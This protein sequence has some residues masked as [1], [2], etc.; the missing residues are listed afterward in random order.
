MAEVQA[1]RQ[2]DRAGKEGHLTEIPPTLRSVEGEK[3]SAK[4]GSIFQSD[5]SLVFAFYDQC[6]GLHCKIFTIVIYDYGI[7]V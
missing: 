6:C 3:S 4:D 5:S 7:G 1:D 2:T